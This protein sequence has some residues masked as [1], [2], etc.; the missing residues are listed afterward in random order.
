MMPV[1]DRIY[2]DAIV[3]LQNKQ[4]TSTEAMELAA[5]A[6]ERVYAQTDTPQRY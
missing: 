5:E 6:L 3:P 2:K 4:I 1:G